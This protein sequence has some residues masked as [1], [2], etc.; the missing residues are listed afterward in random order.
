[1]V[2]AFVCAVAATV[3]PSEGKGGDDY[4][5]DEEGKQQGL[6]GDDDD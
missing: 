4:E 2:P 6:L 5:R 3:A 1:M